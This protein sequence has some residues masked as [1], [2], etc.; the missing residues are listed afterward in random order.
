MKTMK[1]TG[2]NRVLPESSFKVQ[3]F[4]YGVRDGW[5]TRKRCVDCREKGVPK[6]KDDRYV[7]TKTFIQDGVPDGY[8]VCYG[9][10]ATKS[11][12]E[13]S[14]I[15]NGKQG[16]M[17]T[18]RKCYSVAKPTRRCMICKEEKDK[19]LFPAGNPRCSQCS[20]R[21]AEVK[22]AKRKEIERA[23][24]ARKE[25][26]IAKK[27]EDKRKRDAARKPKSKLSP[28]QKA[29]RIKASA[30][31]SYAKHGAKYIE[32]RKSKIASLPED[33]QKLLRKKQRHWN[34]IRTYQVRG[35]TGK[36]TL[37]QWEE[38]KRKCGYKCQHCGRS[39]SIVALTRDHIVPIA[40]GGSND[41]SNIQPLCK[42]CNSS[43]HNKLESELS[44]R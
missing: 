6:K 13:F 37:K 26:S 1:C 3:R 38:L 39:E 17:G 25:A 42:K 18:C 9:C 15:K 8:K 4:K 5:A 2:C 19:S 27:A 33:E 12:S 32:R 41:I 7:R 20:E 10:K 43:K 24:K 23:A 21:L 36:H 44:Y 28:E 14:P 29:A 30:A 31:K 22:E 16:V 35:A 11:I 40:R 34:K